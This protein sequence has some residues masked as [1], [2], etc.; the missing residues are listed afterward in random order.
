[1][2]MQG[3]G[4]IFGTR[5]GER[6]VKAMNFDSGEDGK[7]ER[8]KNSDEDEELENMGFRDSGRLKKR[9][10]STRALRTINVSF[11]EE[12]EEWGRM[13]KKKLTLAKSSKGPKGRER[14]RVGKDSVSENAEEKEETFGSNKTKKSSRLRRSPSE[15]PT[16]RRRDVLGLLNIYVSIIYIIFSL[17]LHNC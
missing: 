10:S 2:L 1:M 12:E 7:V 13:K 3:K 6:K 5:S 16:K 11:A 15:H 9:K 8:M 17:N 14:K 4:R